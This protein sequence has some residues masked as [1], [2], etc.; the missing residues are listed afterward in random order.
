MLPLHNSNPGQIIELIAAWDIPFREIGAADTFVLLTDDA[1]DPLVWQSA[2]AAIRARGAEVVL[3]LYPRRAFHCADPPGPAIAAASHADVVIAM[4]STALNSGTPGLLAI[5]AEGSGRGQTPIWLMEQLT[6][7]ILTT[8][9][10][11]RTTPEDIDEIC[12]LQRRA[13]E[14]LDRAERLHVQTKA[15]A[16]LTANIGGMPEGYFARRWSRRPFRRNP[17]TGRLGGGT[18]PTGEIHVE[19]LPGTA[20]GTMVWDVTAHHPPGRWRSPVQLTID[21]GRVTAIDGGAEADQV[22]RYLSSYGDE[23]AL[24]VGGEIALGTNH[25]CLPNTDSMR[26]EKKRLGA[27]HF[28]IGHGADRG[29]VNS[30]LR[31]EGIVD[32][33]TVVADDTVICRD[34]VFEV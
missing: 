1:V 3:S 24:S 11:G 26:S 4:T 31:L 22:R 20:T 5:R 8:G 10:A 17:E 28:G 13:G 30:N 21:Q 12:D 7:D 23:N 32:A 18:W 33:P 9:G 2:M 14:V 19:P 27:M 6:V 29:L 15:G 25:R 34:G 16:D